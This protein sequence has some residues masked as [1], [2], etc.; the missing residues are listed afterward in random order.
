MK[1]YF[2]LTTILL[3]CLGASACSVK[4]VSLNRPLVHQEKINTVYLNS[5]GENVS[6]ELS[7]SSSATSAAAGGGFLGAIVGAAVEA[8]INSSFYSCTYDRT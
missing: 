2:K 6:I 1:K 3:I 5:L 4:K 7:D 8:G